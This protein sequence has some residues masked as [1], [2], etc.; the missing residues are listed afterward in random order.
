MAGD[1]DAGLALVSELAQ[2]G[3]LAEYHLLYATRADLLRRRGDLAEA[4]REYER[5]LALA[6]SDAERR[7]LQGRI[8]ECGG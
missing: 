2:R 5:A 7:F 8:D 4:I 1:L 6:P 3:E